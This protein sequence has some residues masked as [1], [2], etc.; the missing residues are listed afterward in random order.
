MRNTIPLMIAV[1]LTAAAPAAAQGTDNSVNA[2]TTAAAASNDTAA[3]DN[4]AVTTEPAMA[5][6]VNDM[7]AAPATD[8]PSEPYSEPA[9][10]KKSGLPWGAAGL[11]GL[12]GLLGRKRR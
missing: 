1:A 8:Q 2:D 7:T 4:T 10:A 12:L 5:G 6:S 3:T 9:P 11:L